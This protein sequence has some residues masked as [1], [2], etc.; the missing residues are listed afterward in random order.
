MEKMQDEEGPRAKEGEIRDTRNEVIRV[1][2]VFGIWAAGSG[3]SRVQDTS[4]QRG[5][6]TC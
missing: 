2:R 3:L 6:V 4:I 1:L 5:R